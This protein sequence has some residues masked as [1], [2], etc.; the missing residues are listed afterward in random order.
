MPHVTLHPV[1]PFDFSHTAA[2][3]SRGDPGFRIY[4][5]GIFRHAFLA[6]SVPVV[7]EVRSSGTVTAPAVSVS[8]QSDRKIPARVQNLAGEIIA[9]IFSTGDD[10]APFYLAM[11][12]D[13]VM[14]GLICQLNGL[15]APATPTFFE[16]LTDSVVEQQISLNVAQGI[17]YRMI[18]ALGTKVSAV[19]ELFSCYPSAEVLAATSDMQ[20]RALGLTFRKGE[21]IRGI[22]ELV[23]NGDLDLEAFRQEQDTE[24][25]IGDLVKIRG[26]GRW[27]AELAILRGLHRPEVFPADDVGVRRFI[28]QYYR[29]GEKISSADA[30]VFAERW[31]AWK[32]FAAFYL[33][34]AD[35][36]GISP[37]VPL[38]PAGLK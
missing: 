1:P 9:R 11:A 35:L 14:S 31:G 38:P 6:G 33:E 3:F 12:E 7:V 5:G 28:A 10:L 25:I 4:A 18:H 17:E 15:R 24:A 37:G 34:V 30:R 2:I 13:P 19:G 20:F 8:V 22:A 32:G 21:Y 26:I 23:A 29:G 27:T 16:A 36:L